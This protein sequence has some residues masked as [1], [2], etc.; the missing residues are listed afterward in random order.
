[1]KSFIC[2]ETT[3]IITPICTL[4][5]GHDIGMDAS[6]SPTRME[7]KTPISIILDSFETNKHVLLTQATSHNIPAFLHY[8][9]TWGEKQCIEKTKKLVDK[10][11]D[12]IPRILEWSWIGW[13][14]V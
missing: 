10:S 2:Y 11:Y 12:G 1:L 5:D 14:I 6:T 7:T 3:K 8:S 9:T 4:L 13:P